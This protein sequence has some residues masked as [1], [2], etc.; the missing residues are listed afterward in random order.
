MSKDYK[1]DTNLW[2]THHEVALQIMS[3]GLSGLIDQHKAKLGRN[4][5]I[6]PQSIPAARAWI[7]HEPGPTCYFR[8]GME[9]TDEPYPSITLASIEIPIALRG[10]GLATRI[11]DM[12]EEWAEQSG[13]LFVVENV[14]SARMSRI[15]R[16]RP[17]YHRL[18]QSYWRTSH[19]PLAQKIEELNR[20]YQG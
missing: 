18:R 14:L 4:P 12:C 6:P 16:K 10:A 3:S 7:G 5:G 13:R 20:L 19:A 17:N 2:S 11:L 1:Y 9:Y 15:L 8:I